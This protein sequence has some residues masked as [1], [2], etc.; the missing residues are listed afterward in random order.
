MLKARF[1]SPPRKLVEL[2]R[3]LQFFAEELDQ[4][5]KENVAAGWIEAQLVTTEEIY[6]RVD[7][8]REEYENGLDGE[9]AT[10]AIADAGEVHAASSQDN[11][12]HLRS[13]GLPD[14]ESEEQL[15][16]HVVL[17]VD[18]FFRLLRST[19]CRDCRRYLT[20]TAMED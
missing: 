16:V 14:Q 4:L 13:L 10:T 8:L 5:C 15:P 11:L 1:S 3:R 17:G 18:Y 6:R 20:G 12:G 19:I 2:K 7:R 9:E